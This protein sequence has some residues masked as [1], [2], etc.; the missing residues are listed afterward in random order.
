MRVEYTFDLREVGIPYFSVEAMEGTE[1]LF[2]LVTLLM[3]VLAVRPRAD[4]IFH[5]HNKEDLPKKISAFEAIVLS[6]P[7]APPVR[8]DEG[9]IGTLSNSYYRWI[10]IHSTGV[11]GAG[12]QK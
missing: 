11:F 2:R 4:V 3:N 5:S 9:A 6:A 10:S 7:G 1:K 12:S 8:F